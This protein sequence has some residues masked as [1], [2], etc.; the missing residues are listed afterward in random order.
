MACL[1]CQTERK[2]NIV[3]GNDAMSETRNKSEITMSRRLNKQI[4]G[5]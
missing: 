2:L 1:A 5:H 3:V 4:T